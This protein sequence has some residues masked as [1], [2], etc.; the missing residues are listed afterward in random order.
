LLPTS[1]AAFECLSPRGG[2]AKAEATWTSLC[3]VR[4]SRPRRISLDPTQEAK[5]AETW[6]LYTKAPNRDNLQQVMCVFDGTLPQCKKAM[7]KSP[8]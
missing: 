6:S 3:N 7:P 2:C 8:P 4:I 5:I 1:G